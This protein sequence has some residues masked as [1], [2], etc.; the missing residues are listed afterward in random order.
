MTSPL[1]FSFISDVLPVNFRTA[2][3]T[4]GCRSGKTTLGN[5]LATAKDVDHADEPWL[6]LMLPVMSGVGALEKDIAKDMFVASVSEI[7]NE[8]VHLRSANFRPNDLSSIYGQKEASD[9]FYRLT[10]IQSRGDVQQYI[11]ERNSLCL[12]NLAETSP[13]M[14]FFFDAIENCSILLVLRRAEDVACDCAHKEWYSNEQ[15]LRPNNRVLYRQYSFEAADWYLPWWVSGGDEASFIR[16][17]DLERCLYY[18][19]QFTSWALSEISQHEGSGK[20]LVVRY[21]ELNKNPRQVFASVS[22]FLNLKPTPLTEVVLQK[23]E[24]YTSPVIKSDFHI[25]ND[26]RERVDRLSA[27]LNF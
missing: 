14:S 23:I 21:E 22:E 25:C 5:L 3:I 24:D 10:Q 18:W 27:Q 6:P 7:Y 13:F 1:E 19:C 4:G 26:L 12:L 20:L 11:K 16:Y 15:L 9:I 17:S 8:M 2:I